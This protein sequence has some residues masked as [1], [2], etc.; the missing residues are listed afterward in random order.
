[1]YSGLMQ[2]WR[3]QLT[4]ATS[5]SVLIDSSAITLGRVAGNQMTRSGTKVNCITGSGVVIEHNDFIGT[6]TAVAGA[7]AGS[8]V[9][10]TNP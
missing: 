10:R 3:I 6:G 2:I 4:G 9:V 7:A 1:L 8:M 5:Q